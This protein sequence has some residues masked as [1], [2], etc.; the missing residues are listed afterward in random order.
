MRFS[1]VS[2]RSVFFCAVVAAGIGPAVAVDYGAVHVRT[3]NWRPGCSI[4]E[5]IVEVYNAH[6]EY[7]FKIHVQATYKNASP[8]P[9]TCS[10]GSVA[11]TDSVSRD[12]ELTPCTQSS[13]ACDAWGA[14]M[15][16]NCA[17]GTTCDSPCNSTGW[18]THF[19]DLL[20]QVTHYR[21]GTSGDWVDV[22]PDETICARGTF[23]NSPSCSAEAICSDT[24]MG[25]PC[26][27]SYPVL[28]R[29]E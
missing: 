3:L 15:P 28:C 22:D 18:C 24:S 23:G 27:F 17:Q 8:G 2:C 20:V 1:V 13:V 16:T 19:P 7:S 9:A 14:Q 10:S 6:A 25:S 21:A 11:C 4:P 26:T 29:W 12:F 5:G